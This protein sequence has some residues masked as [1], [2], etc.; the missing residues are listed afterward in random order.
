MQELQRVPVIKS[1]DKTKNFIIV[2]R[3]DYPCDDDD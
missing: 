3:V 2:K 1:H